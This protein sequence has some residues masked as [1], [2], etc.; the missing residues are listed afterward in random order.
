MYRYFE[1][2]SVVKNGLEQYLNEEYVCYYINIIQKL[3]I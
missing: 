1:L 3:F 2:I